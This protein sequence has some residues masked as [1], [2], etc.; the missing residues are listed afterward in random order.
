MSWKYFFL[1]CY[2]EI[3]DDLFF[4]FY[5]NKMAKQ[6]LLLLLLSSLVIANN[7][8]IRNRVD[9]KYGSEYDTDD[10]DEVSFLFFSFKWGAY[11]FFVYINDFLLIQNFFMN[12]LF[13][14]S[15]KIE[16]SSK[17]EMKIH[18]CK[19]VLWKNRFLKTLNESPF[20]NNIMFKLVLYTISHLPLRPKSLD[21]SQK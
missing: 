10:E 6:L 9:E 8:A 20:N 2:Y 14:R 12:K 11:K 4:C 18:S 13:T 5:L 7:A 17:R 21:I 1:K 15:F 16:L 19:N 3:C